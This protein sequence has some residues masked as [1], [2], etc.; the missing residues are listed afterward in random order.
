MTE[1][2]L[3]MGG[4]PS[5]DG[6]ID[7]S[8]KHEMFLFEDPSRYEWLEN[9]EN[10]GVYELVYK[11]SSHLDPSAYNHPLGLATGD[12]FRPGSRKNSWV[13]VAR[14]GDIIVHDN[15]EN[16]NA[17]AIES[18]PA[19]D[20]FVFYAVDCGVRLV[21]TLHFV[22]VSAMI[23]LAVP[24]VSRC[25]VVGQNRPLT[26]L[27]I[28]FNYDLVQSDQEGKALVEQALPSIN[29]KIPKYS[30]IMRSMILYLPKGRTLAVT[31]KGNVS[32]M[33]V[34]QEFENE[35]NQLFNKDR[36]SEYARSTKCASTRP[37][38]GHED[39]P[40]TLEE[41]VTIIRGA[42]DNQISFSSESDLS[43]HFADLGL[44]SQDAVLVHVALEKKLNCELPRSLLFDFTTVKALHG[45]LA[46]TNL[47]VPVEQFFFDAQCVLERSRAYLAGLRPLVPLSYDG[48]P[49][50]RKFLVTGASGTLGANIVIE[51]LGRGLDVVATVRKG[52]LEKLMECIE[53]SDVSTRNL[54]VIEGH[55]LSSGLPEESLASLLE[56]VTDV[57]HNAWRLDFNSGILVFEKDCITSLLYLI[58]FALTPPIKK[59]IHFISSVSSIVNHGI[60]K[61]VR[62]HLPAKF[63]GDDQLQ[64][65][66]PNGYGLSKFVAESIL[67]QVRKDFNLN[68]KIYRCGQLCGHRSSGKWK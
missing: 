32:R 11:K 37:S 33:R 2:T 25:C 14:K 41:V 28:S 30:K 17:L 61:R 22:L 3:L 7:K 19:L 13:F 26:G 6:S 29:S 49:R 53:S 65:A 27:L 1:W 9:E 4:L 43:T 35:I 10:P 62:G 67:H 60:V 34:A 18:E 12:L 50:E 45:A 47:R 5:T 64:M 66:L 44:S 39:T 55:E 36:G 54:S 42:A 46:S 56:S 23:R 52:S 20:L 51:L 31:P 58:K 48:G 16:T 40:I 24:A 59:S 57:I 21:I 15:G 63:L 8:H 68:A 38:C